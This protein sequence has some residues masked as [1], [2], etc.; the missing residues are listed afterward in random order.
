MPEQ[1]FTIDDLRRILREGAGADDQVDLV[2][3]LLD[4]DFETLGYD[5]L[6]RLESGNRIEREYGI[7]LDES[8]LP[9]S[10]T[11]RELI[12]MVN[13]RLQAARSRA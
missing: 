1:Q 5:S 4:N 8:Q 9:G 6:S 2:G 10:L 7:V 11:P 3:D 12:G 13:E